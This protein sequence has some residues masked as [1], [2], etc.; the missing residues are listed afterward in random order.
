MTA[1][2]WNPSTPVLSVA[3]LTELSTTADVTKGDA[4]VGVKRVATGA[5]GQT[6]HDYNQTNWVKIT[7]FEASPGVLAAPGAQDNTLAMQVAEACLN[8]MGGGILVIPYPGEWR[9]NWVCASNNITVY[10]PGGKGEFD[11]NCIRPYSSA[12]AAITIGDGS[13]QIR[14]CGLFNLHISGTDKTVGAITTSIGN[15]PDALAIRGGV[16]DLHIDKCVLYN[17]IRT[18]SMIPTNEGE[19]ISGITVTRTHIRNDLDGVATARAVYMARYEHNVNSPDLGY[20]TAVNFDNV[21]VNMGGTG[22]FIAQCAMLG[23][24]GITFTVTNSYWDCKPNC[25]VKL[26]GS[27]GIVCHNFQLDPGTT[28]AVIIET[29]QSSLNIGRYVIGN[30]RHGGQRFKSTSGEIAIPSEA[31]TYTYKAQLIEPFVSGRVSFTWS[32]NPFDGSDALPYLDSDNSLG[33]MTIN[34]SDWSVKTV[35]KG[36]RTA[37][38]SNAKQGVATLVAGTVTVANTAITANSRIFLTSQVDGGTPG[39]VRVASRIAGTS[40]TITSSNAADTSTIAYE[41]FEPA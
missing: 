12:S 33:P 38:G 5:G 7:D 24:V 37:E 36:Y 6:L 40:F 4:L 11:L 23:N 3:A 17:G 1:S 27:S 22:G 8:A 32:G 34:R 2:V 21:R 29:D 26:E 31:D 15:A 20:L 30:L 41:I 28:N 18:L 13:T 39:F 25:G 9:M 35:G 16:Y 10:G 19:S 14:Y